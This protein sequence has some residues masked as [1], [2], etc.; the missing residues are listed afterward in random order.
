MVSVSYLRSTFQP[1]HKDFLFFLPEV[2]YFRFYLKSM[3]Q[4]EITVYYMKQCINLLQCRYKVYELLCFCMTKQTC[5]FQ[6]FLKTFSL[7][8]K[9]QVDRSFFLS[10]LLLFCLWLI[11][12]TKRSLLTFLSLL[13]WMWFVYF[14]LWLCLRLLFFKRFFRKFDFHMPWYS[15]FFFF[16]TLLIL[17]VCWTA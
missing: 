1:W 15:F 7:S 6:V 8:I 13:L 4:F 3:I 9:Y 5:T 10:P 17:W 16:L 12:F 11:L 14:P 2:V